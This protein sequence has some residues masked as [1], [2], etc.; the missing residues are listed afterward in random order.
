M[1]LDYIFE[2]KQEEERRE[3]EDGEWAKVEGGCGCGLI[4]RRTEEADS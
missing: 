1:F 3:D 2:G 4:G